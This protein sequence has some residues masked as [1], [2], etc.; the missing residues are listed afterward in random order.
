MSSSS[1]PNLYP[2]H[3]PDTGET[4]TP[5]FDHPQA[6]ILRIASSDD[7]KPILYDQEEDEW[8]V[9]I[10]GKA[11]LEIEGEESVLYRGESLFIPAHTK[12]RVLKAKRGTVWLAVHLSSNEKSA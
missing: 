12:H 5:L 6:R 8:V 4:F 7:I 2:H 11:V 9:V 1:T 10:E 3:V